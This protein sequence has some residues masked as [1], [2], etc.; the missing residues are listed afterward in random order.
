[1]TFGYSGEAV[2]ESAADLS[3]HGDSATYSYL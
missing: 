1:M 3:Q 2:L